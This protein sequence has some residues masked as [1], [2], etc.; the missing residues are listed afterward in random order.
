M[1]KV[2]ILNNLAYDLQDIEDY[3]SDVLVE[4]NG[5]NSYVVKIATPKN[6]LSLMNNDKK[7]FLL[8]GSPMI[9]V[10]KFTQ[11]IIEEYTANDG[12]WFKMYAYMHLIAIR[13]EENSFL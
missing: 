7:N 2:K 3:N 11:E 5:V 6:L 8:P 10:K 9:I 12:Y 13:R 4:L 1:I